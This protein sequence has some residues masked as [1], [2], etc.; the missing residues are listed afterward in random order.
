MSE[1]F[2]EVF[3]RAATNFWIVMAAIN[4]L[5]DQIT[6]HAS[7]EHVRRKVLMS[8]YARDANQG[9]QAVH[10]DLGERAGVFVR[11][12]SCNGPCRRRMPGWE[13]SAALK[14]ISAAEIGRAS[15]RERV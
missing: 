13:R 7:Y 2:S 14:K 4:V 15:C 6:D 1:F 11:D 9:G 10:N 3:P 12:D 5:R 8:L